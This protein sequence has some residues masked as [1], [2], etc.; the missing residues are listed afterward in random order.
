MLKLISKVIAA[1]ISVMTFLTRQ[2]L[3]ILCLL[4]Y[5]QAQSIRVGAKH[6]NEGYLLGEILAQLFE[7][8]GYQVQRKY[9]LGGTLI[10]F[11]ALINN[12][13]DIYP[14][15]SGTISQ[16]ILKLNKKLDFNELQKEIEHRYNLIISEPYGFNNTYA[17]AVREN[18]AE[19]L[20]L[21]QISDLVHHPRLKFAF[22]Y[23]FLKR[24]DGWENL[25]STY[26]LPQVPVGIEHGLAYQAI[27]EGTVDVIDVYST[28]GEI[29]RYN[30]RIL[31]DDLNF[32]PDYFAVSLFRP[33]L[34]LQTQ[35]IINELKGKINAKKM[36]MMNARVVF[37]NDSYPE[38]ARAFLVE[39]KLI[40]TGKSASV[41]GFW[42]EI[43]MKTVV[44]LQLTFVA[45]LAAMILAIP[46]GIFI[47]K[48]SLTA[49]PI[50]YLTGLLQTIPSIALLAFMI[51][52]F[53][54]GMVPA[55]VA[56]FL[57][58]LL[59][60]LRNTA[61]SL[62]SIDPLLKKVAAGIGLTP[63]QRL[64]YVEI[65]LA[66]PTIFA[67][68][69]TAAVINIGTATLAAFIG[70]GGLGEFIVTGLALNDTSLIMKGAIPAA[71]LAILV[72]FLFEMIERV[73]V[74]KHLQQMVTR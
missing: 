42:T 62:F 35:E 27:D 24:N 51:P 15:Y 8:N 7:E 6:F 52:L 11:Q 12:E 50:L 68:I 49:K 67:G 10:C 36:Q 39:N 74:P 14:E 20:D 60:I 63:W 19:K 46:M 70:A 61:V 58:A 41:P 1:E 43:L 37:D 16:Q 25:K 21:N 2:I 17:L 64:R 69:K 31:T 9:N 30:L 73:F 3:I 66:I 13:I 55:V 29:P 5:V 47:Y 65:P 28:D 22:S 33:E 18:L 72:E 4:V 54:I 40:K 34:D 38:V 71:L 53:G 56:L 32:F 57:Y 44:H 59:P 23:E 45:L 48:H 26:N